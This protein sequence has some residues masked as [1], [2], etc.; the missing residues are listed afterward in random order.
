MKKKTGFETVEELKE[1]ID[2]MRSRQNSK[3]KIY[4]LMTMGAI[5]TEDFEASAI[6]S[7]RELKSAR[8]LINMPELKLS[9]GMSQIT[10]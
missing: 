2:L 4:G 8:E 10:K 1:A 7:F 9:M 3:F 6:V 5:R